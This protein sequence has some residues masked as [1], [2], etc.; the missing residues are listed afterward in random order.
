MA[1]QATRSKTM[2]TT[3]TVADLIVQGFTPEQIGR[4]ISLRERYASVEHICSVQECRYLEFVR[5]CYA[6]DGAPA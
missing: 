4:L 6:R 5:W 3:I 1:L 2:A